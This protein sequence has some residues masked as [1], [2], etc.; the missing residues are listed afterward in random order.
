MFTTRPEIGGTFGVVASTHWIV[1][2]VAMGILERG[3]NAFDAAVAGGFT[4]SVVEPHLCGPAGEVPIL[5]HNALR[6]ETQVL[7]GQGVAPAA[8]T[9]DHFRGLGLD[10]VP[11]SGLIAAVV[12]GAFDAWMLLLRDHGTMDAAEVMAPAIGYALNGHPLLPGAAR[13]IA[14]VAQA[15]RTEWPSGV[16]TWLPGGAAPRAGA[17]F[18]NPLLAQSWR[19]LLAEGGTQGSREARIDRIRSAWSR[20]F[21]AEAIDRFARAAPLMD[22]SGRR[23]A[24]LL[25]GQDMAGWEARYEAPVTADFAGWTICK[26][27]SWGQG[28]VLLQALQML[29]AAGVGTIDLH[30]ADFVHLVLEAMKLAFA[31]REA[32]YG[33]P[34]HVAVPM[35]SL[36]DPA[37]A[38]TRA[39]LIDGAI[40]SDAIRPGI[41]PGFETQ[42]AR[43]LAQV[44]IAGD[45]AA[46]LGIGE[47]TM[48]H[49]KPTLKPGDTV[50]I[51]VI[52]RHGNMVSATP[53]GGW[54]QSSPMV[55]E[56][57]F[58]LNTRAQMFWL[59]PGLPGSLAP[60]K[61]PRTTLTPTL[62]LQ[63]GRPAMVCGTPGGDQQDQWQLVLLL[64]RIIGG[65]K[66]QQALD[67]PLFHSLHF[68]SSFYPREAMPGVA[69]VE[70]SYG[71]AVIADLRRR[72]HDVRVAPEWSA[73]RL[74]AAER[75]ADGILHAAATPRLMQAYAVG[76]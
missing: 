4:L 13:A 51:D 74:T 34:A 17:L 36:L 50:H 68:P 48:M 41:L 10:M 33:D 59:E 49:L 73:G 20:G 39:G 66:L 19:R 5:F 54:P 65:M 2:Q 31:D 55:P 69:V 70:Q 14:E 6:E 23:H 9:I 27:A 42:V 26:T 29:D 11:G 47:P 75:S 18:R 67:L 71:E 22:A 45:E 15:L 30:G 56:L 40:A 43:G 25:T 8:A 61:R 1:S 32:Y 76:R 52:D 35:A 37:Y 38:R 53:S 24:G 28:P 63:D 64:R 21:V 7:C 3:G 44:R 46:G 58:S 16:E 12:P 62:A 60:G 72:G 57:G